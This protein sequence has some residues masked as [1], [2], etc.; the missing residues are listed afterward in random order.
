MDVFRCFFRTS[1]FVNLQILN[2]LTKK[3]IYTTFESPKRGKI[4]LVFENGGRGPKHMA[5]P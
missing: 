4:D 2:Q 1:N 5:D 3:R